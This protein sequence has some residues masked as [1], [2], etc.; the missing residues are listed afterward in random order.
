MKALAAVWTFR[1]S[2]RTSG[3]KTEVEGMLNQPVDKDGIEK[4]RN[5][6][7]NANSREASGN[8]KL[9]PQAP[10]DGCPKTGTASNGS[11]PKASGLMVPFCDGSLGKLHSTTVQHRS[12]RNWPFTPFLLGHEANEDQEKLHGDFV[13]QGHVDDAKEHPEGFVR[14]ECPKPYDPKV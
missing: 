7:E 13:V 8:S 6:P 5:V 11:I 2:L 10:A 12:E 1:E 14:Q 4:G 9:N 3:G